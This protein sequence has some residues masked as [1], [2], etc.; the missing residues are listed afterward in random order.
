[1][2]NLLA[3]LVLVLGLVS[4]AHAEDTKP[5]QFEIGF[6]SGFA[7]IVN[8]SDPLVNKN[9]FESKWAFTPELYAEWKP[10]K[11]LGLEVSGQYDN[12][13]VEAN[14]YDVADASAGLTPSL[15]LKVHALKKSWIDVALGAGAQFGRSVSMIYTEHSQQVTDVYNFDPGCGCVVYA[16][17]TISDLEFK[18]PA[19]SAGITPLFQLDTNFPIWKNLVAGLAVKYTPYNTTV[20]DVAKTE[21]YVNG[22]KNTMAFPDTP[23]KITRLLS[24][25]LNLS[26]MF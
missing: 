22:V 23:V 14:D 11:W 9:T 26:Y 15:L 20:V 8:L 4:F 17:Q 21:L 7:S 24:F 5:S 16:G 10:Y 13:M 3:I 2:R 18:I 19:K 1:M 25:G 6:R 12:A